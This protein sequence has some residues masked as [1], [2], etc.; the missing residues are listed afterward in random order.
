MK[1]SLLV[2]II[3]SLFVAT[4][5]NGQTKTYFSSSGEMI[6][7]FATLEYTVENTVYDKGNIMRWSPVFNFQNLFNVDPSKYF[8]LFTGLGW[9]N[10][11]FIHE[12][13]N[14]GIKYK[15]RTYNL[16]LPVGIKI[17]DLNGFFVYGGYEI[18]YA[19]NYK[20]KR[21]ENDSKVGK[22]VYWFNDRVT[23]FPQSVLVG[24]NFPYG[25]NLKFKYYLT[26]FHNQDYI[27]I[28]DGNEVKPYENLKSNVFYISLNFGLF[29]P[30]R[31]HYDPRKWEEVY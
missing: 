31:K 20:E 1:K 12:V 14:S 16:G 6:F 28:I 5:T 19:F 24:I 23:Q 21:F 11:G 22:D 4:G 10:V 30:A 27:A 26:N 7:S 18:E 25:F 9:R 3:A 15:Y 29:S 2:L 17:G 13:P 8:G